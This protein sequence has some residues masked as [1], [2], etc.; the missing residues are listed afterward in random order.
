MAEWLRNPEVRLQTGIHGVLLVTA[1][2]AAAII[3]DIGCALYAA[4]LCLAGSGISLWFTAKR[5]D[6]LLQLSREVDRV[7][8]GNDSMAGIPDEEGELAV[9]ASK[10][11][12]MTIRLRDQAEELRTDKAYLQESLADISH[13]VKTPL[14]SIH[15]LLRQL[16]E[17]ENEQERSRISRSIGS[18]LA[19]IEWLI[20]ALLKMASLESGTVVLKQELVLAGDVIQ[21]AAEPLAVPMELKGQQLILKGQEGARYT[22]DFLWSVEALGNILK[23]CME[24][25][26]AGGTVTVST[27]E[28]PVYTQIQVED[29]G[30]GFSKADLKHIFERFYRGE[31]ACGDSVGIGLALSGMIIKE[32]KGTIL[33]SNRENGGAR[34]CIRFYKGAV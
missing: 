29:T 18:L 15:M 14:T 8:Y 34:F 23:N 12:K 32:Q 4:A 13:Q 9:L 26:P 5:Y 21:K 20:A 16:K 31:N 33:A 7:L 27:E 22:G 28:N 19:R 25:T 1:A 11:Y 24:H 2:A 3:W 6:R 10:I 17:E 30:K